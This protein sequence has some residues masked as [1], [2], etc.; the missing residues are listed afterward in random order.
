[1][2]NS[3][4]KKKF[5]VIIEVLFVAIFLFIAFVFISNF[6]TNRRSD[7]KIE[8][9]KNVKNNNSEWYI[10]RHSGRVDI[11]G[12]ELK[13]CVKFDMTPLQVMDGATKS[14]Y[15]YS[16]ID[17]RKE[18]STNA[19]NSVK[20]FLTIDGEENSLHFFRTKE[21]CLFASEQLTGKRAH[22]PSVYK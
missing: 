19:P 5:I 16:V 13:E 18:N 22:D 7:D 20:I 10:W 1:M 2:I 9:P 12:G 8:S 17:D 4:K 14:G 3:N 6:I 11:N 21:Y 15:P